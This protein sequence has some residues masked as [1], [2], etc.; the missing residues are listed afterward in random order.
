MPRMI[1]ISNSSRIHAPERPENRLGF[2]A[3]GSTN[4][5]IANRHVRKRTEK[6][7]DC[8][9]AKELHRRDWSA[10]HCS[11]GNS[12]TSTG[13][14]QFHPISREPRPRCKISASVSTTPETSSAALGR[15]L[16]PR[17]IVAECNRPL[18]I[19]LMSLLRV[20]SSHPSD[21]QRVLLAGGESMPPLVE[22]VDFRHGGLADQSFVQSVLD[23]RFHAE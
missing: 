22:F 12:A 14:P 11:G 16:W 3:T 4:R 18:G 20:R 8:E 21:F 7:P 17:P 19:E 15:F 9:Q 1:P 23:Q 5:L 6:T 10:R 13:E 2:M